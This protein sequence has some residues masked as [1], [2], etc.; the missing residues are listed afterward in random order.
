M[1]GMVNGSFNRLSISV[2]FFVFF[3]SWMLTGCCSNRLYAG[4]LFCSLLRCAFLP[5]HRFAS[6]QFGSSPQA[7]LPGKEWSTITIVSQSNLTWSSNMKRFHCEWNE[8]QIGLNATWSQ[9]HFS[10]SAGYPRNARSR[11][12]QK[13]FPV[14][15]ERGIKR[16]FEQRAVYHSP[17]TVFKPLTYYLFLR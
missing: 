9:A 15:T 8:Q 2:L 16:L 5:M 12:S 6:I 4:K 1:D 3:D 17:F 7:K 13:V 10:L 11:D 14:F